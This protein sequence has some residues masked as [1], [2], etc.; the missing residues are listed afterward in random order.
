MPT[1]VRYGMLCRS[2][3][4][5]P[6]PEPVIVT[7]QSEPGRGRDPLQ[8][9]EN[10]RLFGVTSLY[11]TTPALY[12]DQM[13]GLCLSER[14][15]EAWTLPLQTKRQVLLQCIDQSGPPLSCAQVGPCLQTGL[16]R[17]VACTWSGLHD[18]FVGL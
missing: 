4:D 2:H 14:K 10:L 1:L 16:G 7:R 3:R 5:C 8:A 12:T 13:P 18:G 6:L 11:A 15:W 9:R 17:H